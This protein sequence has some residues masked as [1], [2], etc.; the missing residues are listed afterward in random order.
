[1]SNDEYLALNR[2][3]IKT[4]TGRAR[5]DI[6]EPAVQPKGGH[7]FEWHAQLGPIHIRRRHLFVFSA[8]LTFVITATALDAEFAE[9]REAFE[10]VL[11][12]F[13]LTTD[14]DIAGSHTY[15]VTDSNSA[16]VNDVSQGSG[17]SDTNTTT[18]WDSSTTTTTGSD[19]DTDEK[20]GFT[21]R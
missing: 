17:E 4:V 19:S 3:K 21:A 13:H 15:T 6:D 12:S 20:G 14:D 16:M 8:A 5:M 9:Y 2:L 7:L 11:D 18:T 10:T 1:M